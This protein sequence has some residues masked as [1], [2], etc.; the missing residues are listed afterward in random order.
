[1]LINK[2]KKKIQKTVKNFKN[3]HKYKKIKNKI[4]MGQIIINKTMRFPKYFNKLISIQMINRVAAF[5]KK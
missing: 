3:L 1:M 2:L 5:Y 4:M